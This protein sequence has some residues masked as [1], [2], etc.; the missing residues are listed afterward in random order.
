MD[1]VSPIQI[2]SDALALAEKKASLPARDLLVRGVLA[3]GVLAYATSMVFVAL[4]QG[5]LPIVGA[6]IF[7]IGFVILVLLGLEL[8][9]GNFA[10]LPAA[11]LAK[12]ISASD[13]LRNWSWVY[14]GN[15]LGSV[16]YAVLFIWTLTSFGANNGGPA[17]ELIRAAAMK[18]TTAYAALGAAGWATAFVKA[19]LCNW[20][21]TVG[22]ILALASKSTIGKITG[23]WLPIMMFF[24]MGYEHSIVNMFVMPAGMMAGAPV[25]AMDWIVWNQIP[26]TLGN[27]LGGALLTGAAL[28]YTY[29]VKSSAPVA[30]VVESA[31]AGD[32]VAVR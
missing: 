19:I 14:L 1:N 20:M 8:A 2:V 25:S 17:G 27:I 9:T 13:M 11:V 29:G 3:G 15:L 7:P 6:I 28:W 16:A 26:V 32:P 23:M 10:L 4:A 5:V 30:A 12:R 31:V 21:V 22:A 18:K 24:A